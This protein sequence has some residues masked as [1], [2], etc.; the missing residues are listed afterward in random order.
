MRFHVFEILLD[1]G[2]ALADAVCGTQR[3]GRGAERI[4]KQLCDACL[5]DVHACIG[6]SVVDVDLAV[7]IGDGTVREHDIGDIADALFAQRSDEEAARLCD[8]LCGILQIGHEDVQHV[9]QAGCGV[10]HAVCN[11]DPALFGLDRHGTGTVLRFGDGVIAARADDFFFV[12]DS[13]CDVVAQAEADAA[14]VAG[15]NEAVL[16]AGVERI[17]AVDEFRVQHAVTLLRRLRL[18]VRQALPVDEILCA[19]D[20][21]SG[22]CGGEVV[23]GLILAF[24]AEHAVDIAVFVLRQT[25][26]VDV[27]F[28]GGGVR[29]DDRVIIKAEALHR[30]VAARDSEEG[31]SVIALYAGDEAILAVQLDGAGVH[32]GV[33][34][35]TLETQRVRLLVQVEFPERRNVVAGEDRVLVARVN[36]VIKSGRLVLFCDERFVIVKRLFNVRVHVCTSV[37]NIT[38][39][40]YHGTGARSNGI[41]RLLLQNIV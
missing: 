10:A 38:S 2:T 7:V 18:E 9:A 8:E 36:A 22:E 39:I 1:E 34:A 27:R 40:L 19:D 28:L 33:H 24:A 4:V 20:A 23:Y 12:D 11:V 29:Q 37:Q 3:I 15:F 41:C 26:I 35:E 5:R 25:H 31:L 17:L 14:L 13:V 21:G 30:V 16:W 6:G 32:D